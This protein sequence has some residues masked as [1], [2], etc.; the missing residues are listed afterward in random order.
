MNWSFRSGDPNADIRFDR[1]ANPLLNWF[2]TCGIL[3]NGYP[4]SDGSPNELSLAQ[5]IFHTAVVYRTVGVRSGPYARALF[6]GY[7]TPNL[8]D[9]YCNIDGGLYCAS[10]PSAATY[11]NYTGFD[12]FID[13][14]AV[15]PVPLQHMTFSQN[16]AV[17][18]HKGNGSGV[19]TEPGAD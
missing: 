9:L 1:C 19:F 13:L 4:N 11:E 18:G 17:A 8:P 14:S 7:I 6:H 2:N 16:P 5:N 10:K 15:V 3:D 12:A